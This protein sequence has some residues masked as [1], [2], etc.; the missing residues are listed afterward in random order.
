MMVVEFEVD[1]GQ[2]KQDLL[3]LARTVGRNRTPCR[4]SKTRLEQRKHMDCPHVP[5]LSYNG[6]GDRLRSKIGTS[7]CL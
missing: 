1:T 5:D 7:A 2:A 3:E 6:F 4:R